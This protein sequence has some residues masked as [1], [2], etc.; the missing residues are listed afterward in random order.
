MEVKMAESKTI[1]ILKGAILL[2][3]NGKALYDSVVKTTKNNAIKELF[4]FLAQEEEEHLN[5]LKKQYS[6]V[7]KNQELD[8]IGM[9]GSNS[10]IAEQ[11][12]SPRLIKDIY[13]AGYEAAA[14][15]AALQFEKNAVEYYSENA[16]KAQSEKEQKLYESFSKWETSHLNML[17]KLNEEIREQVWYDNN[18]WPLD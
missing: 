18:F 5:F 8:L 1:E 3:Y 11:V 13:A 12:I 7:S 9:E 15:A 4:R 14:L 10:S 2:E 17:A 6:R 16:E